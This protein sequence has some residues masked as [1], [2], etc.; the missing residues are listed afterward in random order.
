MKAHE[1]KLTEAETILNEAVQA[2]ADADLNN[3]NLLDDGTNSCISKMLLVL[4]ALTSHQ[5]G[6]SSSFVDFCK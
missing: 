3:N 2:K 6:L 5:K 1:G 4:T